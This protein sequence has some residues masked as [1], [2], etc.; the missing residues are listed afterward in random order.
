MSH[1]QEEAAGLRAIVHLVDV[2]ENAAPF[3][4]SEGCPEDRILMELV[5]A[6]ALVTQLPLPIRRPM[7]DPLVIDTI[8]FAD[9]TI[10]D[11]AA[12]Q[13]LSNRIMDTDFHSLTR[14]STFNETVLV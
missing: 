12:T 14:R 5:E 3:T 7:R 11:E 10:C 4:R 2:S 9:V 13:I 6:L 8:R 1:H